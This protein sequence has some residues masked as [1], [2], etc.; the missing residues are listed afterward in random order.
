MN[1]EKTGTFTIDLEPNWNAIIQLAIEMLGSNSKQER[2]GGAEIVRMCAEA[3]ADNGGDLGIAQ[4]ANFLDE[5]VHVFVGPSN[6]VK[7]AKEAAE[8]A[9]IPSKEMV[10]CS[11][12]VPEKRARK[13]IT[14]IGEWWEAD[15]QARRS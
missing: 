15:R 8:L 10:T 9:S 6:I 5:R 2:K 1:I 7:W 13:F 3:L 4:D 14:L 11:R 12:S